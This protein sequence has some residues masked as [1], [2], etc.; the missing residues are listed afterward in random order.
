MKTRI[1][2]HKIPWNGEIEKRPEAQCPVCGTWF[3]NY[4]NRNGVKQ[5]INKQA[6]TE[7]WWKE[8]GIKKH[9]K[10]LKYF[11]KNTAV[12]DTIQ[13]VIWKI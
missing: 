9:Y 4:D 5:H 2:K 1:K 7:A 8:L 6:K 12:I 13:K 3:N 11:K 10:H